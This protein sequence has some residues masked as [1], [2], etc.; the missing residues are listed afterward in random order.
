MYLQPDLAVEFEPARC[1]TLLDLAFQHGIVAF[2]DS[3][4]T[5]LCRRRIHS[6]GDISV[7]LRRASPARVPYP[8]D[9]RWIYQNAHPAELSIEQKASVAYGECK[10]GAGASGVPVFGTRNSQGSNCSDK[11][12]EQR[13]QCDN[14]SWY[15]Q[16]SPVQPGDRRL[17]LR[18]QESYFSHLQSVIE[19]RPVVGESAI[20]ALQPSGQASSSLTH[21]PR[22]GAPGS[23]TLSV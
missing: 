22:Y 1:R 2:G 20:W 18:Q 6:K 16:Q 8:L 5:R 19:Y 10:M 12:Q 11:V 17:T 21:E 15:T 23:S 13:D 14:G 9:P 4:T 7:P 3:C